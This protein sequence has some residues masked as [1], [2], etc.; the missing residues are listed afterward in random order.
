M[1]NIKYI[2]GMALALFVMA[3]NEDYLD[4]PTQ[5]SLDESVIFSTPDLAKGAVDG[6]KVSFGETNSYRGRFLPW[7]G[8]NTDIEWYNSSD[9]PGANA[10]LAVYNAA[11]SNSNMNSTNNTWAKLY[12]GIERANIC[13]RGIRTYGNPEPG[14]E[15][16]YL[17]G[18]ALT[19][20]AVYYS[21]LLKA[22][23]DVVPRFEPISTETL[24]L[25][26]TSRDSIYL[27]LIDDLEEAATLVPWP[28]ETATTSSVERV[29]KAFV[30]GLRARLCMAAG[31]YSQYPD[32]IRKSNDP[33]L[34]TN[35]MYTEAYN[36]CMD[37]IESG[38][39]EL[40]P[41]FE[42]VFK[43]NCNDV[44]AAG[45]ETLWEIPFSDGRGRMLF[46]FAIRH[47][48]VDQYTGQARGGQAGPTPTV[49][50]DYDVNDSRR[51]VTVTPYEWGAADKVTGDAKQEILELKKWSFGK[52][53]YEWM[54]RYVTSSNDDGVNKLYMRYAEVILM[55]AETANELQGPSAA[56]PYLKMIRQRAFDASLW[57][58]EVDN[59]VAAL[60]TK[61]AMF[62]A[63]V[64]E[65]KYE[66]CGEM[67]R[68]EALIRWNL[69]KTKLDKVKSDMYDLRSRSGAYAD[70]PEKVYYKYADDDETLVF[71]GLNRGE[72]QDMSG[73]YEYNT[74]WV[75]PDELTDEKIESIYTRDPDKWQFW[76][77]WQVFLDASNGKL[78][79]DYGY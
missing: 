23:G 75:A 20:R 26:K 51:D 66:F 28:N 61:E 69:L 40:E 76:P 17:L 44:V 42:T 6:I 5:S 14:T 33:A 27:Q 41:S 18:E 79:N 71:Y 8:M 52:F 48:S 73:D 57:N 30:K 39:C 38:T 19:L 37:I 22:W 7:Y 12:E 56:A 65:H 34:E 49:F 64:D 16:G 77:I 4:A 63:I 11:P 36:E 53:R 43:N 35:K 50:Y 60:T 45:G 55:T 10:D 54:D 9:S 46:T 2:I 62:N 1:K 31:G 13:I 58:T 29:N 70:V 74:T 47:N 3:C 24:Y 32:G 21:D 68:K 67:L 25:A 72:D 59:Y 78:V 15:L